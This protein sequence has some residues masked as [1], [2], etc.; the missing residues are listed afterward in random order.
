MLENIKGYTLQH[1]V[2]QVHLNGM[3]LSVPCHLILAVAYFL[4]SL[5]LSPK[6]RERIETTWRDVHSATTNC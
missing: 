1:L 2:E 5:P 6:S 3:T 4:L